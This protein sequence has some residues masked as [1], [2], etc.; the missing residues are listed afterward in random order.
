MAGFG[1]PKM[2]HK[3][4]HQTSD[5]KT[6]DA[7]QKSIAAFQEGDIERSRVLVKKVLT[8]DRENSFALG[9]L[10]T[11]EKGTGNT[12]NATKLFE[13]S[14]SIDQN[15]PDFL[16]NY[17]GLVN[18]IGLAK[19]I[20]LSNMAT[21]ISPHNSNYLERNGYLKWKAGDFDNALKATLKTLELNPECIGALINLGGIYKDLGNLDQALASTLKALELKPDNPEGL[22][23]LGGIYKDLG[24]LD[25]ALTS[26]LKAVQLKP[27]TPEGFVNLG[28]IYRDLGNLDEALASTRKALE[29][30]PR[31]SLA[32]YT[33]GLIQ[34]AQGEIAEAKKSL[35]EAIK[36]NHLEVGAYQALS[37]MLETKKRQKILLILPKELIQ[38]I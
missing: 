31:E 29:L 24:S 20:K 27:Y 22:V 35:H 12:K 3:K 25:Q 16:H 8:I 11:I 38:I 10:A 17:S 4:N 23:N 34:M 26:T 1:P 33:L 2:D 14:I 21:N 19:A 15:N 5:S 18:E 37:M 6:E 7:I 30:N 13:K 36:A 9:L 32:L 28:S